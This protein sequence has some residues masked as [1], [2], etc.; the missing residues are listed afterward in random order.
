MAQQNH[1]NLFGF[2]SFPSVFLSYLLWQGLKLNLV[3][4]V[5][6]RW[7]PVWTRLH[8]CFCSHSVEQSKLLSFANLRIIVLVLPLFRTTRIRHPIWTNHCSKG[9]EITP[10]IWANH[11][12]P[13]DTWEMRSVSPAQTAWLLPKGGGGGGYARKNLTIYTSFHS[14][15]G[16]SWVL[17]FCLQTLL[18]SQPQE[19]CVGPLHVL[20]AGPKFSRLQISSRGSDL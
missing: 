8:I 1:W 11:G 9:A 12:T 10:L 4:L 14:W 16:Q 15:L 7:L 19:V 17:P 20:A 5:V 18:H 6:A 13:L 3:A 2:V